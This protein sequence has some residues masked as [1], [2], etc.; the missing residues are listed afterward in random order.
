LPWYL[1]IGPPGCG[2]TTAL[3]NS[4]LRFPLADQFGKNAIEGTGG[5]RNCDWWFTDEAVLLDTA[6]RYTTQDSYAEVDSA[7]WGGF[8]G[9]LKKYRPR[10]PINGVL[11]A[12]SLADL[13]QQSDAE[14]EQRL[15]QRLL[16]RLQEERDPQRRD[17]IY[18]FPA[19]VQRTQGGS[20][21]AFS[22]SCSSPAASSSVPCCAASTSP[23]VPRRATRST[24]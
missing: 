9:M 7:A 10:R 15:S 3:V 5:T 13:I 2:K 14:R 16:R 4:G 1:I 17:L 12:L 24:G 11:V 19:A 18:A 21:R 23:A 22:T 8:L 6:G 20:P